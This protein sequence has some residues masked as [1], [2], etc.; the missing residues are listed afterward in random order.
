ME[1]CQAPGCDNFTDRG[2]CR[3][4]D[5]WVTDQVAKLET[6][7]KVRAIFAEIAEVD[8]IEVRDDTQLRNF[9][10]VDSL[11][12]AEFFMEVEDTFVLEL[13]DSECS[14]FRTIAD[15]A[16]RVDQLLAGR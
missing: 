15:V 16:R 5:Q 1:R 13:P 2:I 7:D 14:G 4:C 12:V 3:D 11:D 9:R 6:E 10:E 8:V